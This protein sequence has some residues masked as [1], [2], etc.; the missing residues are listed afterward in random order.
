MTGYDKRR[1]YNVSP[2]LVSTCRYFMNHRR[3]HTLTAWLLP[4]LCLRALMPAGFMPVVTESGW[5]VVLCSGSAYQSTV[6]SAG[7]DDASNA[8]NK[9]SASEH[10]NHQKQ[11]GHENI[12]DG[13][14]VFAVSAASAPIPFVAATEFAHSF[15]IPVTRITREWLLARPLIRAQQSRAPPSLA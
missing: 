12:S 8:S 13:S 6:Q 3:L 1:R 9:A 14:C 7:Q 15:D 4:L 5:Q 2:R 11:T 10:L